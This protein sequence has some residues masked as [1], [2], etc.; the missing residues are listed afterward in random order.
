MFVEQ[1]AIQ[2]NNEFLLLGYKTQYRN[3]HDGMIVDSTLP[4]NH[5]SNSID[6]RLILRDG[7]FDGLKFRYAGISDDAI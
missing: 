5:L 2:E 7:L 3:N 1:I 6:P 4:C